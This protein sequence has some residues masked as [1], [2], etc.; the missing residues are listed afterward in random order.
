[1]KKVLLLTCAALLLVSVPAMAQVKL[2]WNACGIAP[3]AFTTDVVFPCNGANGTPR[4]ILYGSFTD[5]VGLPTLIA[6]DGEMDMQTTNPITPTV[7]FFEFASDVNPTGCNPGVVFGDERPAAGCTGVSSLCGTFPAGGQC[8][9]AQGWLYTAIDP[10][11]AANRGKLRFSVFRTA[12]I[13]AAAATEYFVFHVDFYADLAS[14]AGGPCVNCPDQAAFVWN[15]L[16]L[17]DPGGA[18]V[19]VATPSCATWNGGTSICA[20]TPTLNKTWGALKSLYR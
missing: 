20:A 14:Q 5:P 1:M 18:D 17:K 11:I 10:Q 15:S 7:S 8:N 9:I 2:G 4:A 19:T 12:T 3:N 16:V 13:A 6:M